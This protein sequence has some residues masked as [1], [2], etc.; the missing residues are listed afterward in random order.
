MEKYFGKTVVAESFGVAMLLA[1]VGGYLDIYSY[2]ARGKVF[3][4][5]QTGNLVL[6]GYSI[7]TGNSKKVI[8]Y[9]LAILAFMSGVWV[10]KWVKHKFNEHK[11]IYWL[12]GVLILEMGILVGVM[13]IPTGAYNVLANMLVSLVCGLQVQ[14]FNKVH[15]YAYS[16]VMF[17]GNL[18]NLADHI[19]QYIIT[20]E[21]MS[22][23]RSIIYLGVT[24]MFVFGGWF[25]A[26]TTTQ[27][28]IRAVGM[29]DGVLL[30]IFVLLYKER[31]SIGEEKV[32]E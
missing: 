16:P 5:T 1:M 15:G 11:Y 13:F 10:A 9:L 28:D 3:A 12:H 21:R 7:A 8:Y 19:G 30:L 24:L 26:L 6:L 27:Y 32:Q 29:V 2:L 31:K 23:G 20:K 14:S 4:N 18:K 25:G 22:L 17:T